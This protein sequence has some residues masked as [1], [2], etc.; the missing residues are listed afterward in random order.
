M[1]ADVGIIP[2]VRGMYVKRYHI[3][4]KQAPGTHRQSFPAHPLP[5]F[6]TT[7]S[8]GVEMTAGYL[9]YGGGVEVELYCCYYCPY[10]DTEKL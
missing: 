1:T 5:G 3:L 2:L 8:K 6:S 7:P 9:Q 10:T 4:L